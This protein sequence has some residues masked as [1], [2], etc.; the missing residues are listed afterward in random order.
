[1]DTGID[2][3]QSWPFRKTELCSVEFR[4]HWLSTRVSGQ[5]SPKSRAAIEKHARSDVEA[6]A[7]GIIEELRAASLEIRRTDAIPIRDPRR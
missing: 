4:C 6:L 5:R 7:L 1:L 3:P 2:G